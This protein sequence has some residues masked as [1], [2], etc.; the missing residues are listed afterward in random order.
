MSGAADKTLSAIPCRNR[1]AT[2]EPMGKGVLVCIPMQKKWWVRPPLT[3]I[4][5]ISSQRRVQLDE[6]GAWVLEQCDGRQTI[7]DIVERLK[8]K[9]KLS[10]HEARIPVLQFIRMLCE[11]GIVGLVTKER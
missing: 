11:R 8:E 5:P 7:E 9:H 6:T 4:F 1:V 2:I 10:F 3:W